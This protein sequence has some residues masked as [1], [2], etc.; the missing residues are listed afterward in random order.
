MGARDRGEKVVIRDR[1]VMPVSTPRRPPGALA[2]ARSL[3]HSWL[4]ALS[5]NRRDIPKAVFLGSKKPKVE[6]AWGGKRSFDCVGFLQMGSQPK[7]CRCG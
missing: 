7:L 5:Q 6:P 4:G 1:C 2:G 3:L